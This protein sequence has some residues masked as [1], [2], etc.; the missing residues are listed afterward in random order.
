MTT[1]EIFAM[2]LPYILEGGIIGTL[3]FFITLKYVP[4]KAK[5]ENDTLAIGNEGAN[6]A[7][8]R[9]VIEVVRLDAQ[10]RKEEGE[11]FRSLY[12]QKCLENEELREENASIKM[13]MCVNMGCS[14][15]KPMMGQGDNWYHEHR[16]EENLG[17]NYIPINQLLRQSGL[18]KKG[19]EL[20]KAEEA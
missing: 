16:N 3:T 11:Q 19:N 8:L 6:I 14:L 13:M 4:K 10:Q 5:L 12:E 18:S 20:N 7:T 2:L 9:E 15:R 17:C 1:G